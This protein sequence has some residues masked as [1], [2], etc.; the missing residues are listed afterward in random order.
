[1]PDQAAAPAAGQQNGQQRQQQGGFSA[2][3]STILRFAVMW[4]VMN[5]MRGNSQPQTKPGQTPPAGVAAPLYSKG[6][7]L[8]IYVY[9][10]ESP[11][12]QFDRSTQEPVWYQKEV[13]L[14]TTAERTFTYNYRPSEVR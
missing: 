9:I 7:L 12:Y 14:A 4:Y 1:M 5:Y 2:I 11:H 10:S 8:D 13:G 6:D 3:F